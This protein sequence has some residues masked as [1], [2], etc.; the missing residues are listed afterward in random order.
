MTV[1]EFKHDS[2]INISPWG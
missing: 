1:P 2:D